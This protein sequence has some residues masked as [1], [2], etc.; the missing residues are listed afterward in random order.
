MW[1]ARSAASGARVDSTYVY[2]SN[3]PFYNVTTGNNGEPCEKGYNLCTG[4]GSWNEVDGTVNGTGTG[5]GSGSP[6]GSLSFASSPQKLTAGA[7]SAPMALDASVPAP[8]AGLTVSLSTSSP[9]GGFSTAVA[10]PFSRTLGITLAGGAS[11]SGSFYYEDTKAGSPVITASATGWKAAGQTETVGPAPLSRIAV[12][13]ASATLVAGT[14]EAFAASGY[15]RFTNQLSSGV[16]PTWASTVGG[17]FSPTKG[18]T[19]SF[20]AGSTAA[21]GIV[22][23][24]QAGVTGSASLTVTPK[25]TVSVGVSAGAATKN[26]RRY[27]VP[28]TVT[29]TGTS[30]GIRGASVTLDVYSGSCTGTLESAGSAK[31]GSG[32]TAAFTFATSSTGSYCAKASVTATGYTGSSGMALFTVTTAA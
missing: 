31:T 21:S 25:P 6:T 29:A 5:S 9:G 4:L 3:I 20:T 1:A 17:T 19:T 28:V 18:T 7:P 27:D 11:A 14:V 13:P 32:G 10:G 26:G 12:S 2:G 15:D 30:G 24:A 22:T 8:K 16:D 23:A